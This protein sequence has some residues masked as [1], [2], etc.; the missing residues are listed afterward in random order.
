MK[1]I[2]QEEIQGRGQVGICLNRKKG[3][4][5]QSVIGQPQKLP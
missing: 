3:L 5:E 1:S 4:L 2:I